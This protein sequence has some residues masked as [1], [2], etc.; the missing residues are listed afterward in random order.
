MQD[1]EHEPEV[2][3]DRRLAGEQPFDSLLEHE[4]ARVDLVVEGDHL[5]GE[6]DVLAAERAHRP[7]QRADDELGL[8]LEI[9]LEPVELFLERQP[10]HRSSIPLHS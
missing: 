5:V 2:A 7:A 6:L 10:H 4:I 3:R 9:R 8:F 1:R